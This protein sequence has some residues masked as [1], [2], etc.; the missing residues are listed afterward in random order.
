ML[1]RLFLLPFSFLAHLHRPLSA[2]PTLAPTRN[3]A[4]SRRTFSDL[5]ASPLPDNIPVDL[6]LYDPVPSL[7]LLSL[8]LLSC[9]KSSPPL[10]GRYL[11]HVYGT[12][13]ILVAHFLS[14][15]SD[16]P[17]PTEVEGYLAE[18]FLN[19]L[20]AVLEEGVAVDVRS[21]CGLEAGGLKYV[22]MCLL[23]SGSER[24]SR[25]ALQL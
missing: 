23:S 15:C 16:P 11:R 14:T 22:P 7:D 20:S 10:C 5:V 13:L 17:T 4:E 3:R 18:V 2:L 12:H 8:L 24:A 6:A 25:C 19:E 21:T 9:T 1:N